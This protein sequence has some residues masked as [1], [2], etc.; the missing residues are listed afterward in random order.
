MR[1]LGDLRSS[2]LGVNCQ[3]E[4]QGGGVKVEHGGNGLQRRLDALKGR[5]GERGLCDAGAEA[6][7]DGL[8]AGELAVGV[9]EEVLVLVERDEAWNVLA[10]RRAATGNLATTYGCRP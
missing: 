1:G 7:D 2:M 3:R 6:G 8:G 4:L 9:G 10:S 5:H